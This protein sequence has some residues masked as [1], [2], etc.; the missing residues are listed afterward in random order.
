M[1]L[2]ILSKE[3]EVLLEKELRAIVEQYGINHISPDLKGRS[4]RFGDLGIAPVE[5]CT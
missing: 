1:E 3:E 2:D 5:F 4:A